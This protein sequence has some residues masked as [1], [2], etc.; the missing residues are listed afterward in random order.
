MIL[1][2]RVLPDAQAN[3]WWSVPDEQL[4]HARREIPKMIQGWSNAAQW[5]QFSEWS[6]RKADGERIEIMWIGG[7]KDYPVG[8]IRRAFWTMF[9]EAGELW[10]NDLGTPAENTRCTEQVWAGFLDELQRPPLWP[11][12]S[13]MSKRTGKEPPMSEPMLDGIAWR[14]SQCL[15][16]FPLVSSIA[17]AQLA[18]NEHWSLSHAL[19]RWQCDD[20]GTIM[21]DDPGD[22]DGDLCHV[23][24]GGLFRQV[25]DA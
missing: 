18:F 17:E 9:H 16:D 1:V 25:P 15:W 3:V 8:E 2:I 19:H 13:T 22:H 7:E 11:V 24:Y 6:W 23:C 21:D 20:C 10:F 5:R 4:A 14:C 12:L